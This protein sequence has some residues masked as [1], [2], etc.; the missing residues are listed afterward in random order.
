MHS[1]SR[2]AE[3]TRVLAGCLDQPTIKLRIKNTQKNSSSCYVLLLHD[4]FDYHRPSGLSSE[5]LHGL[6]GFMTQLQSLALGAASRYCCLI[7]EHV[8][9]QDLGTGP[10]VTDLVSRQQ[11]KH[12]ATSS[13]MS[14]VQ[15]LLTE[16]GLPADLQVP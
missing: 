14:I 9:V 12:Q 15:R 10:H 1:R 3:I 4:S 5:I 11:V 8:L 7:R 6:R 2:S 13:F 16:A